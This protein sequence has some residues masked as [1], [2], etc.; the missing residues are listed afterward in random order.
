MTG[1]FL[2]LMIMALPCACLAGKTGFFR[3]DVLPDG[4][5]TLR[6]GDGSPFFMRGVDHVQ[7]K[8]H[9]CAA[10]KKFPHREWNQTHYSSEEAWRIETIDRLKAWGFNTLTGVPDEVLLHRGLAHVELLFFGKR[11]CRQD[12]KLDPEA[13]MPGHSP[14]KYF[15]NVF[16]DVFVSQCDAWAKKRCGKLKDDTT[17]VGYFLDNELAWW[18]NA[19]VKD[20]AT[21]TGGMYD[22]VAS[23]PPEHSA[24]KALE[25]FKTGR[26]A[27]E[28]LAETKTRFL[29]F[30][31]ERFFSTCVMA[32]RRYDP[33]HLILGCRFAGFGGASRIV[34][35][36]AARWCDVLS[37]NCYP[38]VNFETGAIVDRRNG[39]PIREVFDRY[40]G[41]TKRPLLV[42][43]WSIIGLDSGLPCS[44]GAGQRV[45]TQAQ[46]AKA[47]E[48]CARFFMSHPHVVGYDWFMWVD[49]PAL[50]ITANGEDANY[51]L[52]TEHSEPYRELVEMFTHLHGEAF[53]AASAEGRAPWR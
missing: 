40:H 16:S 10:L 11:V 33:N 8:G 37:V 36:V 28:P 17:L 18:G 25:A 41:W 9:W 7:Y 32:I 38:Y 30:V 6:D 31:A 4:R 45:K 21:H 53:P 46:R 15:P 52:I 14:C 43:E 42:T 47:A 22:L 19:A 23:L 34:W 50:G 3:L 20:R 26:P 51:G 39:E 35:E 5:D 12:W 1:L 44:H 13:I 24:R 48:A 49:E 29:E 2:R 27:D